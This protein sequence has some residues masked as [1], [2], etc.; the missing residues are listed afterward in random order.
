MRLLSKAAWTL[1]TVAVL[2]AI[3]VDFS[4]ARALWVESKSAREVAP[5][6]GR[7]MRAHDV[8]LY[9][10]EFGDP[11]AP[12]LLL[13]HGTGAW[14]GTWESNV[15]AMAQAGYR[16]IAMDLPPFGFSSR[17]ASRNY[18]RHEQALRILG[19]IDSLQA[20]PVTLLGHSYG[21]GPAAE[22][23]MLQPDRVRQLILLD[24][25][26]GLVEK[27]PAAAPRDGWV[28]SLFGHPATAYGPHRHCG[29][30]AALQRVLAAAVRG[31]QGG[32]HRPED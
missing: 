25:A 26:I 10:Q 27:P 23:A 31:A 5:R 16:V 30:A 11:A 7:W 13:T 17:P 4:W 19:L 2:L 12:P 20:G 15:T 32:G 6:Q 3:V 8:D 22:A 14:S 9:I 29:D 24:A 28:A 1:G 21:G 18:S